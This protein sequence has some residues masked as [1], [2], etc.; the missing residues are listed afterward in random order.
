MRNI[1]STTI[2]LFFVF[3]FVTNCNT[4]PTATSTGSG[5]LTLLLTDAPAVYDSVMITFSEIGAHIDSDWV[6][7]QQSPVKADLLEWTNGE[8]MILGSAEV[9][10]GKYTQI[11][12]KIDE[13]Q[14]GV[15]GLVY[16][17]DIP[18]VST[19]GLKFGPGF[20]V[21][22]GSSYELVLDFDASRSIVVLG[23]K[24]APNG[25]KLKPRIRLVS[26]ALTGSVSGSVVKYTDLPVAYAVSESD[27]VTSALTDTTDGFFRLAFLPQATYTIIV[28]DTLGYSFE[29]DSVMVIPG[30]DLNLGDIILQ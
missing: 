5:Q 13:A 26:K 20:T 8:T 14:I 29:K 11:R 24:K 27:T 10:A 25:Y 2:L 12:L 17:L 3:S 4:D 28:K 30:N 19:S 21:E 18:S 15:D 16:E 1:L 6:Y 22:E 7:I 23:P 9:P